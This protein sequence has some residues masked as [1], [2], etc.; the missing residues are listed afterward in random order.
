MVDR[1]ALAGWGGNGGGSGASWRRRKAAWRQAVRAPATCPSRRELAAAEAA[2]SRYVN[3]TRRHLAFRACRRSR[4]LLLLC[5][6]ALAHRRALHGDAVRGLAR[7]GPR[8]PRPGSGRPSPRASA[9]PAAGS[10]RGSSAAASGPRS[11]SSRSRQAS[12]PAGV[13]RKS[14]STSSDTSRQAGEQPGV[15]AV[16]PAE[17]EVVEQ[18]RRAHVERACG[19][20]ERR[21]GE[22][23]GEEGLAAPRSAPVT[24]TLWCWATQRA[25]A[26]DSTTERSRPRGARKSRSS[27]A[28]G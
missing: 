21:V 11:T 5:R 9:R 4:R 22:G 27:T 15:A 12:T 3:V 16:G 8:S 14:S 20:A 23:A 6:L 26:S 19:L 7:A 13:S 25:S 28:A 10:R 24:T 17:R 1:L 2:T 18:P